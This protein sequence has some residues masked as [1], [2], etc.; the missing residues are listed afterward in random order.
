MECNKKKEAHINDL[1]HVHW[2]GLGLHEITHLRHFELCAH[3]FG[4]VV[5]DSVVAGTVSVL[6]E[7]FLLGYWNGPIWS[8]CS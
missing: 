2:S 4:L 8:V 5:P 1:L 7:G 3:A 6:R